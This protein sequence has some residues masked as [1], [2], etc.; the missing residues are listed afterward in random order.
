MVKLLLDNGADPRA[1][2][3]GGST[4]LHQAVSPDSIRLLVAAGADVNAADKSGRIPI[5]NETNVHNTEAVQALIEAGANVRIADK[6][7][8]TSL[9]FVYVGEMVRLLVKAGADVNAQNNK[10]DTP[11][12][13]TARQGLLEATECLLALGANPLTRN[14]EGGMPRD[15]AMKANAHPLVLKL[16]EK[17][18]EE[19]RR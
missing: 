7:G 13:E 16:L 10:G 18:E 4:P 9:H 14:S 6:D 3:D 11:L 19:A 17:A 1:V 2:D 15:E 8:N 12:H 5:F